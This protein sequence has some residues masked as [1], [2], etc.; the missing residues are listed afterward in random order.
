M[1]DPQERPARSSSAWPW[2]IVVILLVGLI[3][4]LLTSRAKTEDT[5]IDVDINMPAAPTGGTTGNSM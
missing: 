3:A 2:A 5:G 4:W 1:A